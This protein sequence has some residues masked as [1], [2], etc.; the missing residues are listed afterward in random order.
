MRVIFTDGTTKTINDIAINDNTVTLIGAATENTS[1]FKV[2]DD[3]D[4]LI[5]DGT[6]YV[7]LYDSYDENVIYTSDTTV[8]ETYVE[9]D[10]NGYLIGN[11]YTAVAGSDIPFK[12]TLLVMSG[13]NASCKEP[14]FLL[15]YRDNNNVPNF[16][17]ENGKIVSVPED[18]K[19][20]LLKILQQ[21]TLNNKLTVTKKRRI[22]Y[23]KSLLKEYLLSN[24][25]KSYV[26][27]PKGAYYS[28]TEEKQT[29]LTKEIMMCQLAASTGMN[30]N[31][32][33]NASGQ[34]CT[35]DWTME[36]LIQLA[37]EIAAYVKPLISH[38]QTLES[39]INACE[40]CEEIT[41]IEIS[42]GGADEKDN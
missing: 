9:Y 28:V 19:Q 41:G 6:D 8:Y 7:T 35:Y 34:A 10:D 37:G 17:V 15:E 12:N 36:Q 39:M 18:E 2:Y 11:Q 21:N 33:W 23:S 32:S 13:S 3:N 30:Y 4:E 24:P 29:L 16:K 5:F 25:I 40:T 1:G 42:Y 22:E 31:A 38:Q 14:E 27:D 20:Q 26:H